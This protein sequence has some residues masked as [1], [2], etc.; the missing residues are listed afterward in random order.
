MFW[1]VVAVQQRGAGG[2]GAG[3][4]VLSQL[5]PDRGLGDQTGSCDPLLHLAADVGGVPR[6]P[7][8]TQPREH[9]LDSG[10]A[11]E[12]PDT[13]GDHGAFLAWVAEP[14]PPELV[15]PRRDHGGPIIRHD[16]VG[17]CLRPRAPI[18]CLP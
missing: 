14:E 7:L 6:R 10:I 2:D 3:G 16:L 18:P 17:P 15:V 5:D 12:L 9:Q 11:V 1:Y 4:E 8:P 13:R